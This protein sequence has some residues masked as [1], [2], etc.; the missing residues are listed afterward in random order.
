MVGHNYGNKKKNL[1]RIVITFLRLTAVSFI[2]CFDDNC[3]TVYI[4]FPV[5]YK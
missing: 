5:C 3:G 4:C 1:F 2:Y